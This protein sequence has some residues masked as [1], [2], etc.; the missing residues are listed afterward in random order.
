M[1]DTR[2]SEGEHLLQL[3]IKA[4]LE[5]PDIS[6]D[7]C[8]A[9]ETKIESVKTR[10]EL[11]KVIERTKAANDNL[12]LTISDNKKKNTIWL[13]LRLSLLAWEIPWQFYVLKRE[14]PSTASYYRTGLSAAHRA[15]LL[16]PS[17]PFDI[18]S[19]LPDQFNVLLVLAWAK[20]NPLSASSF[21]VV[22]KACSL[23]A[24]SSA[25]LKSLVNSYMD[26]DRHLRRLSQST[27]KR[28]LEQR[29]S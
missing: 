6:V 19:L 3:A 16:H 10:H 29:R 13:Q 22:Y 5:A 8:L 27:P 21:D 20:I 7:D 17:T 2:P 1:A 15:F 11:A 14:S 9:L 25:M 23:L 24:K 18:G 4:V 28:A 26:K 12:L